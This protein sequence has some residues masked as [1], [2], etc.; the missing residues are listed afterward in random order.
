MLKVPTLLAIEKGLGV[1]KTFKLETSLSI[2]NQVL[3]NNEGKIYRYNTD[4]D[5][6]KEWFDLRLNLYTLRKEHMLAKLKKDYEMLRNKVRFIK[7]V[8][9]DEVNIKKV[10]R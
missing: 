4:A 6:V 1:V 3:F 5:I 9:N 2:A 10:K 8:I 7:A